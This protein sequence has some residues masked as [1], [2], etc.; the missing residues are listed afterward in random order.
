MYTQGAP[1]EGFVNHWLVNVVLADAALKAPLLKVLQD[2]GIQARPLW[3]PCHR[4]EAY[5]GTAAG[6]FPHTEDV[7]SRTLSLPSSAHLKDRDLE[8]ITAIIKQALARA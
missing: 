5:A 4:Q 6:T 1:E 7:W 8:Q 2:A 3:L